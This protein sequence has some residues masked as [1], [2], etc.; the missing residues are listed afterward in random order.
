MSMKQTDQNST[1][2]RQEAEE[3]LAHLPKLKPRPAE[4]LLHELQVHQI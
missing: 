1:Q 2:L 3:Q 4:E